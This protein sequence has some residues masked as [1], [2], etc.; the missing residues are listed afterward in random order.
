MNL[1]KILKIIDKYL[2]FGSIFLFPL[3]FLPVFNNP[4]ETGKLLLLS[5]TVILMAVIKIVKYFVD[6]GFEF[7]VGKLDF[8]VLLLT[9][10]YI[11]ST[12]FVSPN[13]YDSLF[14]PGATAFV[15][16]SAILYFFTNQ[17]NDKEKIVIE[18]TLILS[19]TTASIVQLLSLLNLVPKTFQIFGN[20]LSTL[21]FFA[22]IA[23][24]SIYKAL[25]ST[26]LAHRTGY[27]V[28][29]L[30][31]LAGLGLNIFTLLPGKETSLRLP[32]IKTG[33]SIAID[34]IKQSPL[35]GFG[36][37]N[38]NEGFSKLRP[39]E[40]NNTPDWNNKFIVSSNNLFTILSE[41]GL[42]GLLF[43]IVILVKSINKDNKSNDVYYALVALSVIS[44]LLPIPAVTLPIIFVLISL[45][46][47][48]H[49][50]FGRFSSKLPIILLSFPLIAFIVLGLFYGYKSFYS[51]Y[52]YGTAL[53]AISANDG[54]KAY[55]ALNKAI[56]LNPYI[57]RYHNAS[58]EINIAIA[59]NLAK[60][61]D[62][63]DQDKTTIAELIQQ[64][65]R[66]GKAGVSVNPRKS[67][68]WE[69]LGDIYSNISAFAKDANGFAL[70][71]YNQAIFL[72]PINPILR[73]KLGGIYFAD[74]KYAEAIKVFEL[75]VLAKP[76]FANSHYNLAMAYKG[77]K[78]IDKAKAQIEA[79][80]KLVDL[81]SND[82]QIAKNEL[83]SL[84]SVKA[85]AETSEEVVEAE[86]L[87]PPPTEPEPAIE[88][89]VQIPQE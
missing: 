1:I 72:D 16:F 86:E 39:I 61:E 6:G 15:V 71:S 81:D 31:I 33:W 12:I 29:S 69:K 65:I 56:T 25:K 35:L 21:I 74:G 26:N 18:N 40:F 87:T 47:S 67:S 82:Y 38:Y 78:E 11:L 48:T 79:V 7:K 5:I 10:T 70:E 64:A 52:L 24:V 45:N 55:D 60:K 3:F 23:S 44:I 30:I 54:V 59:T 14:L 37:A 53:K 75:A 34:T 27:A 17:L 63:T 41:V 66:E 28:S 68:N 4:F 42:L 83:D 84:N 50:S 57:D 36:P 19:A 77:N 73:I 62:I 32:S 80:L 49:V 88:P 46:N 13:K 89:Q 9:L 2:L 43:F 58:A 8:Y 85:P 51:E 20:L 76:D 22:I